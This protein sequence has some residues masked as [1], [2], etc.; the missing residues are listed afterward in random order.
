MRKDSSSYILYVSIFGFCATDFGVNIWFRI[1]GTAGASESTE[2][3][4]EMD[5]WP[6][7]LVCDRA[8]R[9]LCVE[10]S[11]YDVISSLIIGNAQFCL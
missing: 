8:T 1:Q 4:F 11:V 10:L 5:C 2:F 3:G 6:Y 7:S 9:V